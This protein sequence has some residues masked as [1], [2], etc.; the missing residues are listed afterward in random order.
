MTYGTISEAT[1][2]HILKRAEESGIAEFKLGLDFEFPEDLDFYAEQVNWNQPDNLF[3]VSIFAGG[4]L[5]EEFTILS[6]Y[7][8]NIADWIAETLRSNEE[9]EDW[10]VLVTVWTYEGGGA[11]RYRVNNEHAFIGAP[12]GTPQETIDN[13]DWTD[14][15]IGS[16]KE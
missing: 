6:D 11:V 15:K 13:H 3:E 9:V 1:K 14:D 5:D 12:K 16:E 10:E 7:E 2:L 8:V 4:A